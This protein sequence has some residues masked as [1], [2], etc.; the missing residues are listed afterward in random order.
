LLEINYAN[1]LILSKIDTKTG[2]SIYKT[3]LGTFVSGKNLSY[4]KIDFDQNSNPII[5]SIISSTC[6]SFSFDTSSIK[7]EMYE[8]LDPDKMLTFPNHSISSFIF[9][10]YLK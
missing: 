9:S 10:N 7:K 3:K 1:E 2:F 8:F 5:N 4:Q 6:D